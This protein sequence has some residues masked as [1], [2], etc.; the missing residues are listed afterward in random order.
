MSGL[1]FYYPQRLSADS[2]VVDMFGLQ[3]QS[4]EKHATEVGA[5]KAVNFWK[6]NKSRSSWLWVQNIWVADSTARTF[7][8]YDA[9]KSIAKSTGYTDY[10]TQNIKETNYNKIA[11]LISD[12]APRQNNGYYILP[13][14]AGAITFL[15][16][17]ISELHTKLKN[18]KAN[19]KGK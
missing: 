3:L 5:E 11:S 15:S 13:I 8:S 14:L 10:V 19:N 1:G 18:K 16:Q 6:D 2:T 12:N 17:Y 7:P 9:L 4:F